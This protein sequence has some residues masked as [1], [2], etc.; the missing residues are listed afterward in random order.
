[1]RPHIDIP[2]D[3]IVEFCRR[4]NVTDFAF[5]G[6]VLRDDFGS[7]S[8]IDVLVGFP[9][10]ATPGLFD[11]VAM[12]DELEGVFGRKVDLLT[13]VGV[14]SSHNWIRRKE[15]VGTAETYYAA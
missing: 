12:R 11:V 13:R 10:G 5:F 4:W 3:A 1:M 8:D 14:E 7:D 6:S 9:S 15:I 2:H